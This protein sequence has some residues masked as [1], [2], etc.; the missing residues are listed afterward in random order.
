MIKNILKSIIILLN[1][2]ITSICYGDWKFVGKSDRNISFFVDDNEIVKKKNNI[3][4][5]QLHNKRE[6][7]KWGSLSTVIN[8]EI[9]CS[10]NSYRNLSFE[11]YYGSMGKNLQKRVVSSDIN[12]KI[13][14]P[15][16]MNKLVSDY[17]CKS[18]KSFKTHKTKL[19]KCNIK[20]NATKWNNCF[21]TYKNP[22]GDVYIGEFKE[23]NY[24]GNG[25]Y[26][27]SSS[28][29]LSGQVYTG[30]WSNGKRNGIGINVWSD[31]EKYIGEWHNDKREGFGTNSYSNGKIEKGYWKNDK[32]V[33][34]KPFPERPNPEKRNNESNPIINASSGTGFSI[35]KQGH[36]ITNYHVIKGCNNVNIHSNNM[37]VPAKIINFDPRNDLALLKGKFIPQ[38]ILAFSNDKTNLLQDIYVAGFPFGKKISTSIKITKGIISSLTGIGNNYSNFQIDAAIQPGNSGGP[39]LN[40]KGNVVGIAVAKLDLKYTQKNFGVFPENTNFG[41]K[42]SIVKSMLESENLKLALPNEKT[43]SKIQL[44]KKITDSTY[45]LSCWMTKAQIENMKS[46]KVIYNKF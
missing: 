19:P 13:N 10:K 3:L 23:G 5:R 41:I 44:G 4:I 25:T 17:V 6:L 45:Y 22:Q 34:S 21:G 28:G 2:T 42:T 46:K 15:N 18:Q 35:S 20:I 9:N 37:V 43:I 12:W 8:K 31:G 39:I 7:D 27:F 38:Q 29:K 11:F 40:E 32:F 16:S 14:N 30:E 26:T 36:V 33:S 1:I 24:H